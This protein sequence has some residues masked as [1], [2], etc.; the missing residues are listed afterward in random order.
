MLTYASLLWQQLVHE[1]RLV[2]DGRLPPVL[3]IVLHNG[4][5]TWGA[6]VTVRNLIAL[7]TNPVYGA[8]NRT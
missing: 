5:R 6:P 3:P 1:H 7:P 8:G 4:D 2:A